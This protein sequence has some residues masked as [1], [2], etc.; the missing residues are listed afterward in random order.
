MKSENPRF[1]LPSPEIEHQIAAALAVMTLEE[2]ID[3]LGGV[4][5][6]VA[7]GGNTY[8]IPAAGI[9]ALKMA[10]GPVGVHWWCEASTAYP[11]TIALAASWDRA[12]ARRVGEAIGRDARA[13]GV[14]ILLGPGVNIYRSPLCGRN[15]EYLGEDPYLAAQMVTQYISGCQSQ[16]VSTTVKHYAVNFQEYDRH[17]VSSDIDERTLREIYLPAFRA[18]VEEGGTGALMTSYNLVNGVHCSEHPHLIKEILK[19]EWGFDGVVMSDWVSTY[20][21]ESAANGGL[22]LEMPH[23]LRLNREH[24]LPAVRDG[25]VSVATIDDKVRRLIRL[26]LCFGW[27]QPQQDTTIPLVDEQTATVAAEVAQAGSVLL[28]NEGGILPLD[29]AC[30]RKVAV[31]GPS[32]HPPMI[33]GGGSAYTPPWRAVSIYEGM[34][35]ALGAERVSFGAGVNLGRPDESFKHSTSFTAQ[36]EVGAIAEYF[37][38]V[39]LAGAPV[40]TRREENLAHPWYDRPIAPEVDKAHFSVRWTSVLREAHGG[41]YRFYQ[42]ISDGELRVRVGDTV[43]FDSWDGKALPADAAFSLEADEATPLIVEYRGI[44]FW[45]SV[46]IGWEPDEAVQ[47]DYQA[48]LD[49][50][51]DADVVL[52]CGGHTRWSEGEGF[53]RSFAMPERVEKLLLD[54]LAINPNTIVL[55]TA[56][57]NVDMRRWL[58]RVKGLLHIWYPG[59]EGG[60]AVADLLLGRVNPSGKLPATFETRWEDRSSFSSYHN[61][62]GDKHVRLA[63]GIFCGYRAVDREQT[64]PTFPFG[65]G[66]SYTTF[67]YENLTISAPLLHRGETLLARVEVVNTGARAG[68]EVVQLYLGDDITT[69]PRPAKELKGFAKIFLQPGERQTVEIP[70]TERELQFFDPAKGWVA[71]AGR[72]TILIGASAGDIRLEGS[73]E[74]E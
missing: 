6:S 55:L 5:D 35:E 11:A 3:L 4:M 24:L 29:P 51:R 49:A 61:E 63:D 57:G 60:R 54:T 44:G 20:G 27:R 36:G 34:C 42:Q 66:L 16:G 59:Q 58:D 31:I 23:A 26:A 69:L 15:F 46:Q 52:F 18:A 40:L 1:T 73:F 71:E 14:H 8:P 12:L 37:N 47:Q 50:A 25:R 10:D 38:N 41:V 19:G 64:T 62:D 68:A 72:F 32:A 74:L 65:F 22:D 43:L 2:K 53:D 9:P 30:L 33:G 13:R 56:G 39:E 45:N 17:H 70:I 21:A 7:V 28:R 67:A 48:A